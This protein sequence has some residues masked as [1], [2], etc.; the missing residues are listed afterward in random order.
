[1]YRQRIGDDYVLFSLGEIEDLDLA[2]FGLSEKLGAAPK[3]KK[4]NWMGQTVEEP[5]VKQKRTVNKTK[6]L[7]KKKY[8]SPLADAVGGKGYR[9][10]HSRTVGGKVVLVRRSIQKK[11]GQAKDLA[12][13]A[14]KGGYGLA[15]KGV[16]GGIGLA[17]KGLSATGSGISKGLSASGDFIAKNPRAVAGGG[18]AAVAGAGGYTA[19]RVVKGKKKRRA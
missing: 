16:T 11:L 17:G 9:D 19:Y 7:S 2:A 18:L 4:K 14:F 3:T 5:K 1:M 6:D 8:S 15:K 12:V 13:G 10:A